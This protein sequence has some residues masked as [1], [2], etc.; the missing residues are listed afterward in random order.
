MDNPM[1]RKPVGPTCTL[2]SSSRASMPVPHHLGPNGGGEGLLSQWDQEEGAG[3]YALNRTNTSN[4][5]DIS[6]GS[7]F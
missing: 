2:L 4:L 7:N 5:R 6:M 1:P 3:V